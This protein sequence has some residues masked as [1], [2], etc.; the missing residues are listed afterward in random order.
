MQI[1]EK[2]IPVLF[3]DILGDVQVMRPIGNHELKRH[4][5]YKVMIDNRPYALKLYSKPDR[6]NREVVS[7]NLLGDSDVLV[8]KVANYGQLSNGLEWLLMDW[9]RGEL[10]LNV[11]DKMEKANLCELYYCLGQQM[12][13]IHTYKSFDFFGSMTVDGKSIHHIK[14]YRT[15]LEKRLDK[16]MQEIHM[17]THEEVKLILKS[18]KQLRGLLYTLDDVKESRLCHSDFGPR[19]IMVIKRDGKYQLAAIIDFEQCVP[20]DADKELIYKYLTLREDKPDLAYAFKRGYEEYRA[21]ELERLHKKKDVYYLF[22]GL[23]TCAWAKEVAHDYYL[24]GI[25]GL[26]KVLAKY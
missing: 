26:K 4:L 17:D 16:I 18:E 20:S 25:E 12:G 14:R 7:L 11:Q 10:L 24:E 23:L 2:E 8:P 21:I 6:W 15:V 22:G 1:T 19:N 3:Q 13:M 5:V 9:I